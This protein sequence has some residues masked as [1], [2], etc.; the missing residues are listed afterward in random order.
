MAAGRTT[1]ALADHHQRPF[2]LQ[3][4]PSY[5]GSYD[6]VMRP[7]TGDDAIT[8]VNLTTLPWRRDVT[9]GRELV[10]GGVAWQ[11][12]ADR[13]AVLPRQGT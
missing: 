1:P 2:D 6:S 9:S 11:R 13:Q 5:A 4:R 7:G 10:R 3:Q 8:P 12:A